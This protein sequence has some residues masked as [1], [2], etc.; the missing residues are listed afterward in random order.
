MSAVS[1]NLR[2]LVLSHVSDYPALQADCCAQRRSFCVLCRC[3]ADRLWAAWYVPSKMWADR[4]ALTAVATKVTQNMRKSVALFFCGWL[5]V[6][7]PERDACLCA[8][9]RVCSPQRRRTGC[10]RTRTRTG[11][12]TRTCSC[13]RA[14]RGCCSS[15]QC[16][17][18]M[19]FGMRL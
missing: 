12:R 9:G 16:S 10:A 3:K 8:D 14:H 13:S 2:V 1:V 15:T 11:T 19:Y 6:P 7:Q 5:S 18:R 4:A 17:S